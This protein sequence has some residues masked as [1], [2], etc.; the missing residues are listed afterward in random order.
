M[1]W[2]SESK[3]AVGLRCV[4]ERQATTSNKV[5]TLVVRISIKRNSTPLMTALPQGDTKSISRKIYLHDFMH[6]ASVETKLYDYKCV[7]EALF[8]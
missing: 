3:S 1:L 2:K 5:V 7:E 4:K 6:E 8:N